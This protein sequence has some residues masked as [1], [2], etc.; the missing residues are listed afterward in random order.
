M[1]WSWLDWAA[2][3]ALEGIVGASELI[4]RYK[5][6]V[7][8]SGFLQIVLIAADRAVDRERAAARPDALRHLRPTD[9]SAVDR[10]LP[11]LAAIAVASFIFQRSRSP[12]GVSRVSIQ[13]HKDPALAGVVC[14]ILRVHY[15]PESDSEGPSWLTYYRPRVPDPGSQ[16]AGLSCNLLRSYRWVVRFRSASFLE[17]LVANRH[18]KLE[19]CG[20]DAPTEFVAVVEMEASTVE[21]PAI[22]KCTDTVNCVPY[23]CDSLL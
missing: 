6:H 19:L 10:R 3:A 5:D 20:L 2:V 16:K 9:W 8:P 15:R 18:C 13:S 11:A 1:D 17:T 23:G 14:R 7:G 22:A 21:S 12:C 4:S